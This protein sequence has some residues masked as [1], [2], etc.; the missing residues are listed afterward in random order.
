PATTDPG[1]GRSAVSAPASAGR[2]GS[3]VLRAIVLV[4]LVVIALGA[5]M[6]LWIT[7]E[8][9]REAVAEAQRLE[10]LAEKELH[11]LAVS[12]V[13]E[14]QAIAIALVEGADARARDW[15][16]EEPLSLYRDPVH[17]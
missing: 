5:A 9:R 7:A 17:P 12:L 3:L 10:A 15:L 8:D 16:E 1:R 4:A 2:G 6:V 13:S 14:H 11:D